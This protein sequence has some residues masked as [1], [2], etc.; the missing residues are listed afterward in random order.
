MSEDDYGLEEVSSSYE[1][2]VARKMLFIALCAMVVFVVAGL[3]CTLGDR[4]IGFTRVY[5]IIWEHLCGASYEPG[6]PEWWDDYSV[7][8]LRIPRIAMA[9]IAGMALSVCGVAM[10]SIMQNPLADAYT[11]GISSGAC[12]G[13]VTALIMGFTFSGILSQYGIVTNAFICGLVPAF[14]MIGISRFMNASPATLILAG[15]AVSYMFSALTTLVMI[16][17]DADDLQGAYL[18]QIGSFEDAVWSRIPLMLMAT[19]VGSIFLVLTSNKLN[20]L[21]LGDDN[22]KSLGL[23]ASRYRLVCLVILSLV[24]GGVISYT[25]IIAFVGLIAPHAVRMIIGGDNRFLIPASMAFG[26]AIVLCADLVGRTM[27]PQGELP[28]GLIMS[29]IG[30]PLFLFLI[31]RQ[32]KGYGEVYRWMLSPSM[33]SS[34][35]IAIP[36]GGS[37]YS[38]S[39]ASSWRSS[40]SDCPCRS[41]STES[42]FSSHTGS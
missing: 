32:R 2:Y 24:V 40:R 11:T 12:F 25:G 37:S 38:S 28:V 10:Q 33:K 30:G 42:G 8:E 36:D 35:S 23:D 14:I 31:L 27:I 34:R 9:V 15:T 5:E 6:S 39:H 17:A 26:A 22:A 41:A 7:V 20:V 1:R 16:S 29:F 19:L 13:A 18:W 3:A 4:D 21:T